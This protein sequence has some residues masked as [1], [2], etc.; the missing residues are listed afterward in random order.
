[1]TTQHNLRKQTRV[2]LKC[3]NKIMMREFPKKQPTFLFYQKI[4]PL[5]CFFWDLAGNG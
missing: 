2:K 1:M 5:L 3:I 4:K